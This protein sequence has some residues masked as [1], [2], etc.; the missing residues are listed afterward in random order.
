MTKQELL[1]AADAAEMWPEGRSGAYFFHYGREEMYDE[2]EDRLQRR[3][4]DVRL[5]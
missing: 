3:P 5:G 4:G 1:A 2:A